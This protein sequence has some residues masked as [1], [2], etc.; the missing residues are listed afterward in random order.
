MALTGS[1][2]TSDWSFVR[3]RRAWHAPVIILSQDAATATD[4]LSSIFDNTFHG[5]ETFGPNYS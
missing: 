4:K 2:R 3:Q 1:P 5:T